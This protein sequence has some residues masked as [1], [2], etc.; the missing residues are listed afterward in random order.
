MRFS[1]LKLKVLLYFGHDVGRFV[2]ALHLLFGQRLFDD[3][4]DA[5]LAQDGGER[6]EDVV[7]DAVEA[8]RT[9]YNLD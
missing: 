2:E 9:H 5:V 4:G 6:Q 3:V 8:L 1:R 7:F